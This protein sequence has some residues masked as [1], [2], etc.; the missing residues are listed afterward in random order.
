MP[1]IYITGPT[2][3]GK[4]TVREKLATLGYE[5]YDVD[6][7]GM[8]EAVQSATGKTLLTVTASKIHELKEKAKDRVIYLCGTAPTDQDFAN[9]FDTIM[10]LTIDEDTQRSRIIHRTNSSYGKEPRQLE[11][12]LSWR[13]RQLSKYQNLG[14][15]SIDATQPIDVVVDEILSHSP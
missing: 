5:T 3:S 12:A 4:S 1:L 10:L 7:A 2:G 6:D 9:E 15:I 14:A 13:E 11:V 8:R